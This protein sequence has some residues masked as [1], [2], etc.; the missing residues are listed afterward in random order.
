MAGAGPRWCYRA[1]PAEKQTV[2]VCVTAS[3]A[4]AVRGR[5]SGRPWKAERRSGEHKRSGCRRTFEHAGAS[6]EGAGTRGGAEAGR[7][8]WASP[9]WS[10]FTRDDMVLVME[11]AATSR[12]LRRFLLVPEGSQSRRR[13]RVRPPRPR[14][15]PSSL[16]EQRDPV[17]CAL[18]GRSP[19]TWIPEPT[20]LG[21][22][23]GGP[24]GRT[25]LC[26]APRASSVSAQRTLARPPRP[27][28]LRDTAAAGLVTRVAARSC[29][30]S[31]SISFY[32]LSGFPGK[33]RLRELFHPIPPEQ[34]AKPKRQ[35]TSP[36]PGGEKGHGS[37]G[38]LVFTNTEPAAPAAGTAARL[39]TRDQHLTLHRL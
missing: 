39:M 18:P 10:S 30:Q 29:G 27:P 24:R 25:G 34:A 16:P 7:E 8:L 12:S 13:G 35:V 20:A 17:G 32:T 6:E 9:E 3:G 19:E 37:H 26:G 36:K 28:R 4:G 2:S 31:H 15:P 33:A 5:P 14:P 38:G 22:W 11:S 1:E 21:G 23:A